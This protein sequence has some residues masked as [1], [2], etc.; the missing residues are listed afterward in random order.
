M[1]FS[2]VVFG[3]VLGTVFALFNGVLHFGIDYITSRQMK[4]FFGS[5]REY[6][7]VVVL[8]MDQLLHYLMMIAG[9]H[10]VTL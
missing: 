5:G 3:W 2:W 4:E 6:E 8:G 7:G 1:F 10:L 9:Y